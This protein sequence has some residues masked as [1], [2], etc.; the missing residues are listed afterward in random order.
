MCDLLLQA[1]QPL[2]WDEAKLLNQKSCTVWVPYRPD[3]GCAVLS[4][5]GVNMHEKDLMHS[6]FPAISPAAGKE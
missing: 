5:S 6:M 2:R 3:R 4:V 1:S